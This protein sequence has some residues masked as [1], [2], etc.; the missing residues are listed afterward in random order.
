MKTCAIV[1]LS[2]VAARVWA[3]SAYPLQSVPGQHYLIDQNGVPFFIQGDSP[4]YLTEALVGSD[5]DYYLS[6]RW[7]QGYNSVILDLVAQN[8]DD[9]QPYDGNIYGQLPFTGT[10]PG[11]Y[12][13]LLSWN[14]N[15]FTNVDAVIERAGYYG[16][17]VF[18]YP[19]YDGYQGTSWYAQM[20]GNSSNALWTYG[21]FI[22]NRYKGFTNLV[23]V[24]AGDDDEPNAPNASLWNIVANGILSADTNH[25]ITAQASRPS[26]ALYYG[27]FITLNSSYGGQFP[28]MEALQDYQNAPIL[29]SFAREPY[30][31]NRNVTGTPYTALDC[32]HFAYWAVLSGDM[33]HFYGDE[34]QWPFLP[35]W[36]AEMWDA[37]ATSITNVFRLME[38]RPWWNCVPDSTHVT[39]TS[40]Y[41]TY[42]GA[43]YVACTR[44]A[45]GKTVIAYVPQDVVTLTVDLSKVSGSAINAWWYNPASGQSNPIGVYGT[46]GTQ[47]FQT[48]DANDWV[49]V[50]DDASQGYGPPGIVGNPSISFFG[51]SPSTISNGGSS[52]LSWSVSGS[53]APS[54]SI[55]PDIGPISSSSIVVSPSAT[56]T[57]TLNASNSSGS[58]SAQ[59]VLTVSDTPPP[60]VPTNLV[61]T[62]ISTSQI[63]LTW[64]AS[65]D[66][67]GVLGYQVFRNGTEVATS[68]STSYSDTGLSASTTYS[69]TVEAFDAAGNVSGP[70][71][72]I[73]ATTSSVGSGPSLVQTAAS[74]NDGFG[75]NIGQL[76]AS[77]NTQGNLIAVVT[78]WGSSTASPTVSDSAG[79]NY[80][81]ACSA[82]SSAGDQSLAIYYAKSIKGGAN[83]VTVN[84]GSAHAYRR[85]LI[86]EYQGLDAVSPV[87]GVI[88]NLGTASTATDNATSG[89]ETTMASGDLI[90]G[91]VENYN[92]NG[93][94]SAGTG[95]TMRNFLTY[96]G[97]VET[98]FEDQV[99]S[100]A[101]STAATYTFSRSDSYIAQMVAFRAAAVVDTTPPSIPTNLVATAISASQINLTWAPSTD[102]IGVIG[103]QVFRNG[104][105]VA[106]SSSTSFSD[107]GLSGSTTYSYNVDAFDSAGNVSSNSTV[108]T[109]TTPP[110]TMAPSI[111]FFSA[112]PSVITNS[113]SSMLS[114]QVSGNPTPSLSIAPGVGA[115]SGTSIAVSPSVSTTYT[116]S[117]SNGLGSTSTQVVVAV[118]DTMPPSVA[119]NLTATAASTSQINL[120]WSASTDNVAVTGYQVSRNGVQVGT[121]TTNSYSD[122]GLSASTTYTYT[123]AAFDAATNVSAQSTPASATTLAPA[124]APTISFFSASPSTISN[125]GS[126]TLSWTVSGNPVPSLSIAPGIGAVSGTSIAVSPIGSTTYTL[127]ASNSLGSTSAQVLVTVV[128][129]L[130]PSVPTN[131]TAIAI[132]TSQVN[133]AWSA[134]TDNVAVAGYQVFRNGVQVG[135][136]TTN[137]YSDTGLAASTTYTYTVA[138]FDAATNVSGQSTPANATTLASAVA[139]TISFFS[140]SPS[141]ISNS[142]SATLSW[143]VS[144]NPVPSLSIAPG[145][146]TVTGTSIAVSPSVTTTYTLTASN[147]VGTATA[148]AVVTNT[149]PPSVPTNLTATAVSTSQINLAWSVSTGNVS[150]AGYQVFRNG[151]KVAT[152]T[153]TV[154]SDTGLSAST[155]YTYTVAAFDAAGNVSAQST[156]ASATTLAPA[157]APTVSFFNASPST[158]SNGGSSTL[159]WTV[160]GNPT[161]SLSIAPGVGAVSGTSIGVSPNVT[162]TYTLTASNSAG[163]ATAQ[164]VIT[165]TTPPSVPT[166]L[167]ATA[168]STSQINLAWSAS[169]GNVSVAGYQVFRNGA[170]V[171]TPTNTV[172]SDTGLSA[173]TTYTYTVAAVDA[174]GNVSAQSTPAS[175]TT[176]SIGSPPSSVQTAASIA[177]SAGTTLA[178]AFSSANTAGNLIAVVTSWGSP[179]ATA[180]PTV[181]D[182]A[183]NTYVLATSTFSSLGQQSLAIYYARNIRAGANTVTVNFGGSEAWR[184][185]LITEYRG[186]DPVNPLDVVKANQGS[187]TMAKDNVTSGV[188]TTTANGDLIFGAVENYNVSGTLSAGT[189]FTLRNFLTFAGV[190]ETAIEDEVQSSAG[191][192]AATFTFAHADSYIAQV[193]AFR[194]AAISDTIPPSVPT[195]L[196]ATAIST[197]QINLAWSASTDNVAVAGYQ[198]FRN[199]VQVGTPTNA[200]YSDTGLSAS[201]TYTYK[202]AAFDAAGNVSAQSAPASATTLAPAVAPTISF[203]SAS[204]STISNGGSSTLSWTVSGNPTPSL[205][206]AP[207]IGAVS[208]TSIGVSPNVTTTYTLTASNS[209]GT[210]TAQAVVTNT[211]PPSV[212]TNLIATAISTSQINLA[213]SA[214]TGNVSVAGYQVFRNGVQVGTPT[215]NSYSDTGLTA[216][217]TYTYTVAAFDAAG[218]VSGQ[219]TAASATTLAPAVAPTISFFGA[220]PSTISNSGSATLS[221]TVSGSP[222][223]SLSIAPGIGAVSGTSIAVSPIGSTTYTLSASNIAGSSSTQ[224]VVTV[225]DTLPPS[226]PTNLTATANSTSQINL[227]WSASTDN[228]AVAGYQVFRNGAQVGTS[229]TNSYSDMGLSASTTYT[230]TVAAFDAATNVSGQSG[231][232][233]ATTQTPAVAP[234]ISFFSASPS[235]ISNGSSATLS[236]T[237]SGNPTPSLSIAPGIGAVS[238]TSIGVSPNVTTTYT[239]TASNSAGTVTAQAVVTNT[240][241]PSVPTNLTATAIS[242]SQINLAWSA[243]TGNVSVAGYQ[244]FRNGVQVGTPTTNSYSDTGLSASTTYTYM[245]AAFDAAGNV[246]AQ[247]APA[248][249]T[250]QST[251]PPPSSVQTAA[252]IADSAGTTLAQAFSSA[253]TASNLITVVT[254]WGSPTA[255]ANP[256]VSDS[257]GNTYVLATSTFSSLGQQ[258][259]A[260]YYAKNIR[261]GANTVTVDFGGSRAWRRILITE[262]RG[263][264]PVNPVDVVM[265]N[266]GSANMAKDNVTSGVVTTTASGDLIFGAVE[267]YNASGTL[268]A[269][270]SFTLRNSVTFGGVIETAIEDSVQ[271]S[272]GSAAATFTFTHADS[273]IAQVV[274]FRKRTSQ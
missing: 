1:L 170:K 142:G 141:T 216:S 51:A 85:I 147:S 124:V 115:V 6:N 114:W 123:V 8:K 73:T 266:Q 28:Y 232:A 208:G 94:V 231:P 19:L 214:S 234:T 240:T 96:A 167:I 191:S 197:S 113:G 182:S 218:N 250:T 270:T 189:G 249:V 62:A 160:S 201:T 161:P 177:D 223:P 188:V 86:A 162:T 97:V 65:T 32:R 13:N 53:P 190:I 169:T 185:I 21:N 48:P 40:G 117:V 171:A 203:F 121:T 83:T 47:T 165:N 144:G 77:T 4:W 131:L 24:G 95:F 157:V 98:A 134:S 215:T 109:A 257:A 84:F 152:P 174:A 105:E 237:V 252:S 37:G 104:S 110:P 166:N 81:V 130:P 133:L 88:T 235:T 248:S 265:A 25:L 222:T 224:V 272:A 46:T 101:G 247:S 22:G 194:A 221:W 71:A 159:S 80:V 2:F 91:A 136:P 151:V 44:E 228:V 205:S 119:T 225:V 50:L 102:N 176:Q 9:G 179:T 196:S 69:Y 34:F 72:P 148:Q 227:A 253:N 192:A 261:A 269:G 89:A 146:G 187:A 258:S 137:A 116:L 244:V 145:V 168:I 186:I 108:A 156:P 173:S 33:G 42:G 106:T 23:W 27:D 211:T 238:G 54:L 45:T 120:A 210:A 207:G 60:W 198:V 26:S 100:S 263:I 255:T 41:G 107:A 87:D 245:V 35:G 82:Y 52:T 229:T 57:Y 150:V 76:F 36:Q 61:A 149:T 199:G 236:W 103:Y 274:A 64:A 138:A 29:A 67:A 58:A 90:F 264:D 267:N 213:W 75:A 175:A 70:S 12:T 183:G 164:A 254:S 217:T 256:T 38:T 20:I 74:M 15:Y 155:T 112:A 195:N 118:V 122:T 66:D 259:L 181:S 63:N 56:S 193:V 126:A 68:G 154:Y 273:Y 111:S 10:I 230:Y 93:T 92:A 209:A 242:T 243:S 135:S 204:P 78:S 39:V 140:A 271:S 3:G 14:L 178:Q 7:V 99:Q 127:S 5:V 153:N 246:S 202:V 31:E 55:V 262:Y 143:T 139:P 220:S 219:S 49:L 180:N 43:N 239:L 59:V 184:R 16:I 268:S 158:I 132:S 163:T 125:S 11:P 233:I 128:D 200:I 172:Y 251:A 79:N 226:V 260:I 212:P 18:A 30:Y 17:N 206:I 241:P 129:T